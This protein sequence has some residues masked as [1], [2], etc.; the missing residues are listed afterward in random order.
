MAINKLDTGAIQDNAITNA[1]MADDAVGVA[2][3][4]A[5]GTPSS[6]TFLRGDNA[7]DTPGDTTPAA[8]S[9]ETNTS[10]GAFDFP[11]GTTGQRPGSPSAGYTRYNTTIT[12]LEVYNGTDWVAFAAPNPTI[13]SISP[14][15][16]ATT[17]VTVTVTGTNFRTGAT[18]VIIGDNGTEYTPSSTSFVSGTSMTL[19]TPALT[20][21]N[22]PYDIKIT[23]SDNG[24]VTGVNMLDAGGS[25]AWT[26]ASGSLGTINSIDTGTHATVVASDPD[27]TTLAYSVTTGALPGGLSLH[28]TTGVISGDPT[29]V[30]SSTTTNFSVTA[31]D[32]V[33]TSARAFSIT[34]EP[35]PLD[36]TTSSQAGRSCKEIFDISS[37]YQGSSANG[38]RW[39]T[40]HGTISATQHYCLMDTAFNG[41]G[42]T[43]LYSMSDGNGFASGTTYSF[44]TTTGTAANAFSADYGLDRRSTFTPDASDNFMIRREDTADWRRFAVTAWSPRSNSVSNGWET[45]NNPAGTNQGHPFWATGQMYDTSGSAASG[46]VYFN[47]CAFGGSCGGGGGDGSGFGN[48]EAWSYGAGGSSVYGGGYNNSSNGGSPLFWNTTNINGTRVSMWYRKD[49]TQ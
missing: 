13:S 44:S 20:V 43:L 49:G 27:G 42:W 25:P 33:N 26:T 12:A 46:F 9:D 24:T 19:V 4:A 7:W 3:L 23:N 5:T 39:V 17:G 37:S 47:G 35:L 45:F 31:S 11:S 14:T 10:Q 18:L 40:N 30:G 15:T 8:I 22:E 38:L 1:K 34:V 48:Y 6:T 32:G 16:A 36:G 29:D 2:D 21:A 41:G 28:A